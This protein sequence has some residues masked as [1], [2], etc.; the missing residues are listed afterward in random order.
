[1][2]LAVIL[3]FAAALYALGWWRARRPEHRV[4]GWRALCFLAGELTLAGALLSPLGRL[5]E[6][7]LTL[8][9]LQLA[10]LMAVA[11]PLFV[12]A[13]PL[14]GWVRWSSPGAM[15]GWFAPAIALMAW[16]LPAALDAAQ[17]SATLRAVEH[18]TLLLAAALFWAALIPGWEGR[19]TL[20]ATNLFVASTAGYLLLFGFVL[21]LAPVVLYSGYDRSNI[22]GMTALED[23]G[24]AGVV[25][26]MPALAVLALCA[27]AAAMNA[28]NKAKPAG[29]ARRAAPRDL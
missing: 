29:V 1:V 12:L 11:A 5:A 4:A 13:Q 23:Q 22:F 7:S 28:M 27:I 21:F 26:W 15:L 18:A 10:L 8:H 17:N 24:L 14:G 6:I 16:H 19:M 20:K 25:L 2:I 9:I 3:M